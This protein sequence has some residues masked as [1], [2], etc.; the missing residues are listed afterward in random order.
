VARRS[1]NWSAT[2]SEAVRGGAGCATG[3]RCRPGPTEI[4]ARRRRANTDIVFPLMRELAGDQPPPSM[5]VQQKPSTYAA[6]PFPAR[7]S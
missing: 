1:L 3:P 4:D 5:E 7:T 2:S 6:L